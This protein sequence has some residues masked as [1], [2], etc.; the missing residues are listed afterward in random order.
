[1]SLGIPSFLAADEVDAMGVPDLTI[2]PRPSIS[3]PRRKDLYAV[4]RK[5]GLRVSNQ[6]YACWSCTLH[7][8]K[9]KVHRL[10]MVCNTRFN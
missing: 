9:P 3:N 6:K 10:A 1:M 2:H 4:F 7:A 8:L 5:I